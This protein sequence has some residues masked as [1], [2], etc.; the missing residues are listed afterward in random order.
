VVGVASTIYPDFAVVASELK[1][2][3]IRGGKGRSGTKFDG[4]A[5]TIGLEPDRE[6]DWGN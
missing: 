5:S 2:T 1:G 6:L 3:A 4:G